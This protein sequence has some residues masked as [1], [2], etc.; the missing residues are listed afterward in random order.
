MYH[1][2]SLVRYFTF[3]Q[4]YSEDIPITILKFHKKCQIVLIPFMSTRTAE[5]DEKIQDITVIGNPISR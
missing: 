3:Y 5:P 4:V 1:L 2:I